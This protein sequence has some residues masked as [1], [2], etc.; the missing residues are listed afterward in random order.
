MSRFHRA[1]SQRSGPADNRDPAPCPFP[2]A[3]VTESP[4]HDWNAIGSLLEEM[5]EDDAVR[6]STLCYLESFADQL[7][8]QG[9][10]S[11]RQ[12]EIIEDIRARRDRDGK[13]GF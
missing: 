12:V 9:S 5:I 2:M 10:L 1:P 4:S 8:R 3:Q 13:R 7:A 11:G 6:S